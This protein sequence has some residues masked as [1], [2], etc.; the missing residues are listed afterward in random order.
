MEN[1]YK[2]INFKNLSNKKALLDTSS[3]K[4]LGGIER[5]DDYKGLKIII[6]WIP[7]RTRSRGRP[8]KR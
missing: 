3:L 7:L 4:R 8:R 5:K 2:P 1:T 6:D